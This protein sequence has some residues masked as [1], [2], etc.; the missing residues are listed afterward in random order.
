MTKS[1]TNIRVQWSAFVAASLIS[2]TANAG[3]PPKL[4]TAVLFEPRDGLANVAAKVKAGQEVNVV[5]LGGSITVGGNSPNGYVTF[6]GNWLKQ[7]YPNAKVNIFDAGV[8]GTGSDFGAVRYDRDVLSKNPDLVFIEFCVNDGDNDR[9]EPME[10]MVHKT[11]LKNPKADIVFFYT[12]EKH[13]LP[14]YQQGNLPPSASSHERVAAFYGIPSLGT[15]FH[16]ASKINS[17]EIKW[18]QFS[19][20]GCH[21]TQN[22]YLLFDEVFAKALPVLLSATPAKPHE[23]DKSITPNL[24]VYPPLHI[25]RLVEFKGDLATTTGEKPSKIY[26]LPVPGTN[27]TKDPAF[28]DADGKTIWHLSWLPVSLGG[29]LDGTVGTDKTQWETNSMEWLEEWATYTG[30]EGIALFGQNFDNTVFGTSDKEI[31]VIRFIAP[32][33]GRYVISVY[34]GPWHAFGNSDKEMS[35]SVLKFTWKGGPGERLAFQKEIQKDSKGLSMKVETRML[36]G[37]EIAFVP[38]TN[39]VRC[40]WSQ[41]RAVV[42][43]LGQ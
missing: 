10:R 8:S 12:L 40:S 2:L 41:F 33:T 14:Y 13:H 29:K 43:F 1:M 39:A 38:D 11:W 3:E 27:W 36:A 16:A 4:E 28:Q 30:P 25:A 20:D 17:G 7:N 21:P 23:L 15:A 22:G 31:G 24:V 6:V 26:A 37:E 9:T 35:L 32:E 34:S 19:G 42:G 5:F 18:E